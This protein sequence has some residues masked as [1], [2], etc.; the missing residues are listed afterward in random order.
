MAGGRWFE[1]RE[2]EKMIERPL[3]AYG[4]VE[5]LEAKFQQTVSKRGAVEAILFCVHFL[6]ALFREFPRLP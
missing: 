5:G 4:R 6:F 1:A 2:L 3:P